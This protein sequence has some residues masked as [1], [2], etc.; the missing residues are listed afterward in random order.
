MPEFVTH[1]FK[2]KMITTVDISNTKPQEAIPLLIEAQEKI[3]AMP[4]KSVL[5]LTDVTNASY[6]AASTA[7]VKEFASKNS[8][9][10]K[11]SAVVGAKGLGM[12]IL[13][14]VTT[15]VKRE[16]RN[17]SSRQQAMDWLVA[18]N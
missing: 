4:L 1:T 3:A 11:A 2:G 8:P 16:I 18:Q 17:F 13:K 7:V 5:I 14:I 10:I 9:Y 12:L 15:F 6:D